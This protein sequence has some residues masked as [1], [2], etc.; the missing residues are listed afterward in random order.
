[1]LN[2]SPVAQGLT[3]E[4][5]E[6]VLKAAA[7]F[8]YKANYFARMLN[9]KRSHMI[10]ILSPDLGEGYDAAILNGIERLL[11]ERD[12]LYFVSSHHWNRDLIRQ[13][14][15]VFAERGAEGVILINTPADT[16]PRLPIVAIGSLQ[17]D[18]PLTSITVDNTHGIRLALDHLHKLGH[19]KIA[20]LKG[21][22]QSSDAES[23]WAACEQAAQALDLR[24]C[25]E[26]VLQLERIDDGLDPIREGYNAGK[27]LLDATQKFTALLAFNDL[28]AIGAIHAFRD[29]GKQIPQQISVVGFDDIQA[30]TIVQPTLTTIC[31]WVSHGGSR[32]RTATHLALQRGILKMVGLITALFSIGY[33]AFQTMPERLVMCVNCEVFALN[34]STAHEVPLFAYVPFVPYV[35]YF[36]FCRPKIQR[37]SV[38][39]AREEC[40]AKTR[41]ES[42]R[43]SG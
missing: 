11:I 40:G 2:N 41:L 17:Y 3:A 28:S 18:F 4:T 25:N 5:R 39:L 14:L 1:M 27:R 6:R 26:H 38:R 12:Y 35:P 32:P 33:D 7:E 30:A 15:E 9:N 31:R 10:G 21:H 36:P 8:N 20:F 34:A 37:C 43:R 42:G 19:R 13:R 24:I 16:A 29:A 23:R 22:F